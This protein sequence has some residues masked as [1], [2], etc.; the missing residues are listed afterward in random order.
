MSPELT[1]ITVQ[2]R[3]HVSPSVSHDQYTALPLVEVLVTLYGLYR[4]STP[5]ILRFY[6][7]PPFIFPLQNLSRS[8]ETCNQVQI[9]R[10]QC[11]LTKWM[12]HFTKG[13]S[14]IHHITSHLPHDD[15]KKNVKNNLPKA[16]LRKIKNHDT[17]G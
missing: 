15:V 14:F 16:R 7:I 3:C 8:S 4:R 5:E 11:F 6:P 1:P 2:Y 9:W 12:S 10:S 13:K 17:G